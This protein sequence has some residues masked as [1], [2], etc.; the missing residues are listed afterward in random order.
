MKK[1]F[2]ILV[3]AAAGLI[4]CSKDNSGSGSGTKSGTATINGENFTD[5]ELFYYAATETS[6]EVAFTGYTDANTTRHNSMYV[7][8][9]LT[10]KESNIT[11]QY[12]PA[13]RD[14]YTARVVS[15]KSNVTKSGTNYVFDIDGTDGNGKP[16]KLSVTAYRR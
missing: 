12:M 4:S 5:V 15:G 16:V 6:T 8:Y 2:W 11:I 9:D 3:I 7:N 1:L 10:K 13:G 14:N